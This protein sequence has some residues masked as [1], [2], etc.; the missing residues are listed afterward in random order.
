MWYL[1]AHPPHLRFN[2][3]AKIR[4]QKLDESTRGDVTCSWKCGFLDKGSVSDKEGIVRQ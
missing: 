1:S 2:C 4:V 3:I